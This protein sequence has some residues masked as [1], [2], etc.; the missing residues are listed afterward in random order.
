MMV[1]CRINSLCCYIL[2]ESGVS[3]FEKHGSLLGATEY[4]VGGKKKREYSLLDPHVFLTGHRHRDLANG[5]VFFIFS[6]CEVSLFK[7][8]Y[9]N[10]HAQMTTPSLL[11]CSTT[12][13]HLFLSL[14]L[15]LTCWNI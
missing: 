12:V 15:C 5:W 10:P 6:H 2:F 3:V 9:G 1:L 11:L 7:K 8:L 4:E 13:D 14:F